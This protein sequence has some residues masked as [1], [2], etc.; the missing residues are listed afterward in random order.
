[1]ALHDVL[2]QDV[3]FLEFQFDRSVVDCLVL[4]EELVF[5]HLQVLEGRIDT[6]PLV[7]KCRRARRSVFRELFLVAQIDYVVLWVPNR[8]RVLLDLHE[9]GIQL[10]LLSFHVVGAHAFGHAQ[11]FGHLARLVLVVRDLAEVEVDFLVFAEVAGRVPISE[12]FGFVG[13]IQGDVLDPYGVVVQVG[14]RPAFVQVSAIGI[15]RVVSLLE[16]RADWMVQILPLVLH[17]DQVVGFRFVPTD[18]RTL[19]VGHRLLGGILVQI[20]VDP[21]G[22]AAL[23]HLQLSAR[24]FGHELVLVLFLAAE[25]LLVAFGFLHCR[26]VRIVVPGNLF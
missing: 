17:R 25:G 11:N 13:Q 21:F 9:A 1:M 4:F 10:H 8:K 15:P 3:V 6:I 24:G 5:L 26:L 2:A 23:H 19:P 14:L 12:L 20:S 22:V 18:P 7:R 16:V